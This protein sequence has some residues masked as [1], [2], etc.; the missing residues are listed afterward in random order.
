MQGHIRFVAGVLCFASLLVL[1]IAW[2]VENKLSIV[3]CALCLWERWPWRVLFGLSVLA[4]LLP[5]Q[6]GRFFLALCLLPLLVSMGLSICHV[7]VEWGWWAS[8]LPECH[9]PHIQ[10]HTM[11]EI[12]ASMPAFPSKPC[13]SPT[14]LLPGVPI[15]M[16]LMDGLCA[17]AGGLFILVFWPKK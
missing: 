3:P 10:G 9:A 8:P 16:A 13:D 1:I 14:Y 6:G 15:S 7:G 2:W 12:L 11:A 5:S 17:G 4:L